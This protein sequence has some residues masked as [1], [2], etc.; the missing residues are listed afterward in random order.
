MLESLIEINSRL[1]TFTF[2][3]SK[4]PEMLK[5]AQFVWLFVMKY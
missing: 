5:S 1:G 4:S 3:L 2:L